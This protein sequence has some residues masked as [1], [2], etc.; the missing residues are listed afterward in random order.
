MSGVDLLLYRLSFAFFFTV[1]GP[2]LSVLHPWMAEKGNGIFIRSIMD[3]AK[4]PE[5]TERLPTP[6]FLR[7]APATGRGRGW[8]TFGFHP[9]PMPEASLH[10]KRSLNWAFLPRNETLRAPREEHSGR[11][12]GRT[13][14]ELD[15][16]MVSLPN[17]AASAHTQV[18]VLLLA[19]AQLDATVFD[20]VGASSSRSRMTRSHGCATLR[21]SA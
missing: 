18:T 3:G 12:D 17:L 13:E 20:A 14:A 6:V 1:T 8:Q 19:R 11:T 9:L 2:V 21:I 5:R 10:H 15:P 7:V 16:I 4:A